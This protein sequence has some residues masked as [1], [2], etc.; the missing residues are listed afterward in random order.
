[1]QELYGEDYCPKPA[2]ITIIANGKQSAFDE[3]I[4]F[5]H[6][7]FRGRMAVA[8]DLDGLRA[9]NKAIN[10]SSC[11]EK[12]YFYTG[13]IFHG[14]GRFLDFY[15]QQPLNFRIVEINFFKKRNT[16]KTVFFSS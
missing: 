5:C 8:K 9:M 7:V 13:H 2:E 4:D 3:I 11:T 10:D 6:D 1:M 14:N 16:N 12:S 15:D